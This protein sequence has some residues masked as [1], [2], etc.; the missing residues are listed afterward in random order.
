MIST[1]KWTTP[2][3]KHVVSTC[4]KTQTS[5]WKRTG[6]ASLRYTYNSLRNRGRRTEHMEPVTKPNEIK[7]KECGAMQ[8]SALD[9]I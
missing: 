6:G 2:K 9:N 7:E 1:G 3:L 5:T 4:S 8:G